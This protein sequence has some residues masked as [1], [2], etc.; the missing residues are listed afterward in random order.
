MR[1]MLESK[2]QTYTPTVPNV[3][4]RKQLRPGDHYNALLGFSGFPLYLCVP[5]STKRP[6]PGLDPHQ[7]SL[8]EALHTISLGNNR[9]IW[10]STTGKWSEEKDEKFITWFG[11]SNVDGLAGVPRGVQARYL[12]EYKNN[13]VGKHFKWISQLAVF[14]LHGGGCDLI[15]F[16]LWKATGELSALV[17]CTKILDMDQYMVRIDKI[18]IKATDRAITVTPLQAD[19][20]IAVANVLD[21]W[22]KFDPNRII[23]KQ[24]LHVLTHLRDDVRQF[25]PPALYEVEAFESSNK[26]FRQCSILSNHH[27][28]S[29]DIGMTMARMERFKHIISGGWWWDKATKRYVQ[30]GNRITRDFNS[31]RFL[32]SHLRWTPD[33]QRSPGNR[34]GHPVSTPT[35]FNWY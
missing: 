28:P 34:I 5:S 19:L 20:D 13:L 29:H 10:F 26:V 9:Y 8:L 18:Y 11:A 6:I 33:L 7:D 24:K 27:T 30:A 1:L 17:W 32:Q 3:A 31:N 22:A 15:V 2:T 21:I 35:Q 14:S 4:A 16:D 25:G 23:V 12:V